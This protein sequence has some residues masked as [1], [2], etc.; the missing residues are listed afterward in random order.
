MLSRRIG[1]QSGWCWLN[2]DTVG[3]GSVL[4]S[5]F[6][7]VGDSVEGPCSTLNPFSTTCGFVA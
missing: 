1:I 4:C 6:E 5:E 7:A 2:G 3:W